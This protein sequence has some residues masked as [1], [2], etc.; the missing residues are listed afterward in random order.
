M[1]YDTNNHSVFLLQYHLIMCVKYRN[2][3]INK[4]ISN[5]LKK[6][7]EYISPNYNITLEEWNHDKD[8]KE[9]ISANL[10]GKKCFGRKVIF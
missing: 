1:K 4:A 2:K 9:R 7:F 3:V 6:I 8:H 10:F 5:R